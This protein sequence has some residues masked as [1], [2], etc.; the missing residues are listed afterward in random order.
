MTLTGR[1]KETQAATSGKKP[2]AAGDRHENDGATSQGVPRIV[3]KP[4]G[5]GTKQGRTVSYLH[6][7]GRVTLQY[8]DSRP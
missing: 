7:G 4:P 5:H 1:E 2:C 6:V 3:R 8:L